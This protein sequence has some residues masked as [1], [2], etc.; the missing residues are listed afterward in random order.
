MR[1]PETNHFC[2]FV[3]SVKSGVMEMYQTVLCATTP[4]SAAFVHTSLSTGS[5]SGESDSNTVPAVQSIDCAEDPEEETEP[6]NMEEFVSQLLQK[7]QR[8]A[9]T[10]PPPPAQSAATIRSAA[11]DTGNVQLLRPSLVTTVSPCVSSS[12]GVQHE[13]VLGVRGVPYLTYINCTTLVARTVSLNEHSWDTHVSFTPLYLSPSPFGD[14]LLVATDKHMHIVLKT[15][16]NVRLQVL[17]GHSCGHYGKPVVLWDRRGEYIY[18][19]SDDDNTVK[20]YSTLT[21]KIVNSLVGHG[22]GIVRCLAAHKTAPVLVSGSYDKSVI[23]W[24]V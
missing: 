2:T 3:H 14:R 23:V 9:T 21:G 6:E 7:S 12:N 11:A 10:T 22:K 8:S 5:H 15:S 24:G 13:L 20:V 16:T 4:E 1:T 19:N 17:S 18:C